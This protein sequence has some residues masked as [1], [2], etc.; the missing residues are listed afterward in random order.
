MTNY[1]CF[2]DPSIGPYNK[3]R[4]IPLKFFLNLRRCSKSLL[5]VVNRY[6]VNLWIKR[7]K[8]NELPDPPLS[9]L[10]DLTHEIADGY[11]AFVRFDMLPECYIPNEFHSYILYHYPYCRICGDHQNDNSHY[12]QVVTMENI[13]SLLQGENLQKFFAFLQKTNLPMYNGFNLVYIYGIYTTP[14][15]WDKTDDLFVMSDCFDWADE[16]N[17]DDVFHTIDYNMIDY[18]TIDYNTID[19]LESPTYSPVSPVQSPL[20]TRKRDRE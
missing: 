15:L 18:N 2:N 7:C 1:L 17:L 9:H 4:K 20:F 5:S 14:A 3:K 16:R 11:W 19:L 8:Y 6:L 10:K 13:L 12:Y